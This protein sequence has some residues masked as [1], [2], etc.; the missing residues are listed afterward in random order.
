MDSCLNCHNKITKNNRFCSSCGQ[1]TVNYHQSFFKTI[2]QFFH[3]TLD[4]DGR[5][6]RTLQ[7]LLFSPGELSKHFSQGKRVSYSPPL[8][9]YLII[10][11]LFFLVLSLI[12][13]NATQENTIQVAFLLFPAGMLEQ[14]PK[15]MFV[16][17]PIFAIITK[18]LF[19]KFYF[20]F[21]LVFALHLHAFLYLSL[22]VILPAIHYQ[23]SV[24]FLI[25]LKYPLVIYLLY[26]P[27]AAFK[28]M[29]NCSWIISIGAYLVSAS[30]YMAAMA[31][32]LTY[33][34]TLWQ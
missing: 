16:L 24:E 34:E 6:G 22:M 11:L 26:Y 21:H 5:L 17:V 29:F 10:S 7:L 14:I 4:I 8:R 18:A 9:M 31:V 3:E 15:L 2:K 1:A 33:L 25:W 28:T 19:R 32:C 13:T 12:Q 30:F 23:S 27:L 20:I